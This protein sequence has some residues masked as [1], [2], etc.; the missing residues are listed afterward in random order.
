M[1]GPG[2]LSCEARP[3][4]VAVVAAVGEED[5]AFAETGEHV[6]GASPVMSLAGVSFSR[7]GSPLAST[8]AWIFVVSPPREAPC[9]RGSSEVP[10]DGRH[11]FGPPSFCR[12]HHAAGR[13]SEELSRRFGNLE[14]YVRSPA[15]AFDRTKGDLT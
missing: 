13:G 4:C 9:S 8:R 3:Q 1:L 15:R 6:V 2:A 14:G 7:M 12:S 10:S 5:L 11:F